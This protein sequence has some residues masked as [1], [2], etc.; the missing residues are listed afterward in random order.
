[1]EIS[2]A[3]PEDEQ[4]IKLTVEFAALFV[5]QVIIAEEFVIFIAV[6]LE[7]ISGEGEGELH[8]PAVH[9]FEHVSTN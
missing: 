2:L 6:R 5:F 7:I 9:P 1:M 3:E 4:V 8:S